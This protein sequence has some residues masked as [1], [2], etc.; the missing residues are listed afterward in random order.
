[1]KPIL[2]PARV[3]I[4]TA[5]LLAGVFT[6][7][8]VGAEPS[9]SR[10]NGHQTH[11]VNAGGVTA[12]LTVAGDLLHVELTAETTGWISI[13]FDPTRQMADANIIIGYVKDGEVVI[14]DDYG[15]SAMGH[16]RDTSIGG[17]DDIVEPR[18]S[19]VDGVTTLEFAIPLDSGD[20]FDRPLA[21]GNRHRILLAHGPDRADNFQAYHANRGIVAL[22]L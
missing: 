8:L 12:R 10:E 9:A 1:M 16:D 21:R 11:T 17:S 3:A 20:S 22:E 19:E 15:I 18:G 7:T 5:L 13:G 2:R 6:A 4:L 14:A